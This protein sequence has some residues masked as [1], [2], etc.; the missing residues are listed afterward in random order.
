MEAFGIVNKDILTDP[1]LSMQAKGLYALICTYA[2]K[3]RVCFPSINTLADL[4]DVN[5]STITRNLQ[6]LKKKGYIKR[7]G[8]KFVVA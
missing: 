4:C 2:N 5:P 3:E 6:K 1:E 7:I 8:R